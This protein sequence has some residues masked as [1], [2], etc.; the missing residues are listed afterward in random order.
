M[1]EYG[2][3]GVVRGQVGCLLGGVVVVAW[4]FVAQVVA[5]MAGGVVTG[6]GS[7]VGRDASLV[8]GAVGSVVWL[9]SIIVGSWWSIRAIARR[10]A[11]VVYWCA[12]CGVRTDPNFDVCRSCGRLKSP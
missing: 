3:R 9:A 7:L 11:Q 2:I 6:V 1:P 4:G 5:M 8:A 12:R 10:R